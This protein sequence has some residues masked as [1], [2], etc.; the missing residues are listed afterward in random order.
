MNVTYN[1]RVYHVLFFGSTSLLPGVKLVNNPR[2]PEIA[3]DFAQTYRVL[4]TLPCDVF[5]APHAG[6]FGLSDK[7]GRLERGE[8]PNPFIDPAAYRSFI[9]KAESKF[10]KQLETERAAAK[11]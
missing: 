7:A 8:R 1:G 3:N 6:F 2:Y 11:P 5:L 10:L 9:A 4:K